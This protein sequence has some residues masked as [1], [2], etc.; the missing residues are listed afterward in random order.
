MTRISPD[1]VILGLLAKQTG[2]GYQ[3]LEYFREN[4]LL[5]RI[6]SLRTPQLYAILK[7][8]E[9]LEEIDG[10]EFFPSDA[11]PRTE[12]WLTETGRQRLDRWLHEPN[13]S[14]STRRIRTEFL[15]RLYLAQLIGLPIQP[16]IAAQ[17]HT[18]TRHLQALLDQ[19]PY[20]PA[21]IDTL[22]L[23]LMITEMHAI[24]EWLG[25]CAATLAEELAHD[26]H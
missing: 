8:L 6:W 10:C 19:R 17:Q 24:I 14:P 7:R 1:E 26:H 25:R 21:G 3:L 16:I 13:P 4:A 20:T 12:Y 22:T 5:G 2:H 15:S 23:D 11:P 9:H 18:C